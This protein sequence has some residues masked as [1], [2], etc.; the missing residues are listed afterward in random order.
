MCS[1]PGGAWTRGRDGRWGSMV[2]GTLPCRGQAVAGAAATTSSAPGGMA[3][4]AAPA[5]WPCGAWLSRVPGRRGWGRLGLSNGLV[6]SSGRSVAGRQQGQGPH[7]GCRGAQ[8]CV[9]HLQGLVPE[10]EPKQCSPAL[11]TAQEHPS[12]ASGYLALRPCPGQQACAPGSPWPKGGHPPRAAH[13]PMTRATARGTDPPVGSCR[14]AGGGCSSSDPGGCGGHPLSHHHESCKAQPWLRHMQLGKG[15]SR[16][17]HLLSRPVPGVA[18][19]AVCMPNPW[20]PAWS[21]LCT[22]P[23]PGPQGARDPQAPELTGHGVRS[24]RARPGLVQRGLHQSLT[25]R[26]GHNPAAAGTWPLPEWPRF[27]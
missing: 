15:A 22:Y 8:S 4:V 17:V 1:P 23:G 7:P 10:P 9:W 25:A 11:R 3:G 6:P 19:R 5:A 14:A 26:S 24:P 27:L 12:P 13:L 16:P 18:G 20:A 21:W 2:A